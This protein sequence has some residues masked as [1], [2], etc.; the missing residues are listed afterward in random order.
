MNC[1]DV[2][3]SSVLN[4]PILTIT[5][6]E[7]TLTPFVACQKLVSASKRGILPLTPSFYRQKFFRK[8]KLLM[9]NFLSIL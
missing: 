6:Q 8:K 9:K 5:L 4:A 2:L 3:Q 7:L 1:A